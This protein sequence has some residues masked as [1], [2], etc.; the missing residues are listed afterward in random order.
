MRR[1]RGSGFTLIELMIVVAIIAILASIA[2]PAYQDYVVRGQVSE[3]INLTSL[4]KAAIWEW[5]S[6]HGTLPASNQ[7]AGLPSATS[8]TGSYVSRVDILSTGIVQVTFNATRANRVLQ[9]NTLLLSPVGNTGSL[10]WTCKSANVAARY[11]PSTC[12]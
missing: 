9:G 2:I 5:F 6:D 3:G 10:T 8:I 4:P 11:L 1:D 12:R 7:S